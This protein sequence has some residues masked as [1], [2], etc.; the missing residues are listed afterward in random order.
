MDKDMTHKEMVY[1]WVADNGDKTLRL[2]YELNENSVVI[3]GGGYVGQWANEIYRKY[4]CNIHIFE[5]VKRYFDLINEKFKNN[6]KVHVYHYGLS[7]SNRSIDIS[8]S[9]DSSSV[10]NQNGKKEKINLVDIKKFLGELDITN[11]DLMKLN[12]EGEEYNILDRMIETNMVKDFDNLQ[13]QFHRFIKD[14][15]N[16]KKKI[17]GEILKSHSP[18]YEYDYVWVNYKKN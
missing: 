4:K 15:D 2:N 13:L 17:E 12:V 18:T 11:V 9:S 10:Y 8:I 1:K 14:Y 7:D 3:D 6:G 16:R 5:P